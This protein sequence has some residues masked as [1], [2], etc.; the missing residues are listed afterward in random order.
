MYCF[1]ILTQFSSVT[2]LCP[3]LCNPMDCSMP[4]PL[5]ITNSLSLLKLISIESAMPSNHLT[6]CHPLSFCPQFSPASGSFQMSRLFKSGGPSIGV[7]ASAWVLAKNIS[8]WF[9]LGLTG[10][11][12]LLSKGL[13]RVFSSITIQTHQF[14]SSQPSWWFNSH[15]YTWRLEKSQLWPDRPLL[16]RWWLCFLICCL[17]LS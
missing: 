17:D 11:I 12:F 14:F 9:L 1:I 13:S 7:S 10:L 6:L 3:T 5:P 4:G 16:A 15:I 8:G 2:Q